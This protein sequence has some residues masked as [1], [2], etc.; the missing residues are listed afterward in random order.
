MVK[1]HH[2][3]II[4]IIIIIIDMSSQHVKWDYTKLDWGSL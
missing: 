2:H 4:I 1:T 3:L